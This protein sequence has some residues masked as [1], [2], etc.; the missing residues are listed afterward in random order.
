E[1]KTPDGRKPGK[2]LREQELEIQ[3]EL[4]NG[5][6]PWDGSMTLNSLIEGYFE[7]Q[8]PYWADATYYNYVSTYENHIKPKFGKRKVSKITPDDISRFYESLFRGSK[9]SLEINTIGK[10]DRI[11]NPS[12]RMAVKKRMISFNPAT[13]CYGEL[14]K[15]NPGAKQKQKHALE[16]EQLNR[17]LEFALKEFPDYYNLLYFMAWTGCRIN[18]A[19]ALTW[20]DLDFKNEVIYIKRSVQYL[21]TDGKCRHKVKRPKTASGKREIPMLADVKP[22]LKR[23]QDEQKIVSFNEPDEFP[24]DD[25]RMFVFLNSNQRLFRACA[26]DGA[27]HRL[28]VQ[29]NQQ[30]AE[31]DALPD[32]TSHILRH[33][34][35]CWL[36]EHVEGMNS[37]DDLKYIQQI[38]G[39][40][41]INTT[42]GIYAE[43]RKSNSTAKHEAL[44]K[45]AAQSM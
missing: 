28:T 7:T 8:K 39:H 33:T 4:M 40:S 18:E 19:I 17:L 44:K 37:A 12:F 43:C 10:V 16:E 6:K 26:V 31:E 13:G 5:L 15:K 32:I 34:F 27:L 23:M 21:K 14:C 29:F 24:G 20:G 22:M 30:R 45:R 36:C 2:S 25:L 41:D 9:K 11:L 42:M 1:D 35:C 38:M 3:K